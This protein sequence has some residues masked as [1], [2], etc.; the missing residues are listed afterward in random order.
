[1]RSSAE[2]RDYH[3]EAMVA[4]MAAKH[5]YLRAAQFGP[6]ALEPLQSASRCSLERDGCGQ[7]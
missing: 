5:A 4:A 7:R 3:S 6:L 2:F 1:V